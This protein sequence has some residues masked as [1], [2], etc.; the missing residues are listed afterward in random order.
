MKTKSII[1]LFILSLLLS[2]GCDKDFLTVT[3][4]SRLTSDQFWKNEDDAFKA[5]TA[6]YAQLQVPLWSCWGQYECKVLVET[7]RTDE[8]RFKPDYD[9]WVEMYTFNMTPENYTSDY[10]WYYNWKGIYQTNLVLENVPDIE[11]NEATKARFLAEAKFLRAFYH[12]KLV[13]YY[14]NIPLMIEV[15]KQASDYYPSQVAPEQIYAQVENDF[16]VAQNHLPTD[17]P[18]EELGRAT[19]G[20][21]TAFLGLAYLHQNKWAE[22]ASEFE[23]VMNMGYNL[24]PNYYDNFNGL[25]ENNEESIFEVQYTLKQP[26]DVWETMTHTAQFSSWQQGWASDWFFNLMMTDTTETGEY[27][28]RVYG[29]FVFDDPDSDVFYFEGKSYREHFGNDETKAYWKKWCHKEDIWDQP[30]LDAGG[31]NIVEMRYADVLL[32]YAE[33]QNELGNTGDAYTAINQVR[34][35]AGVAHLTSG[36][37]QAQMREHIR[38]YERPVELAIEG[39]RWADLV[40]WGNVK[41]TLQ[42]HNHP[43]VNTFDPG[44]DEYLPIPQI[45]ILNDP[46][47]IQNGG[48]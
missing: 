24:V 39:K 20:A 25:N 35:R 15:P 21:A 7:Y 8:A 45:D 22:A 3:D 10:F 48:Y 38:H 14:R 17:L 26:N 47:L 19:K 13:T 32:M 34:E 37:S 6:A 43:Y 36:M 23:K 46:N 18:D 12:L 42:G 2:F 27:S 40:R 44:I 16:R 4:P 11:M 31:I 1:I 30:Y 28:Q 9:E 33:V 41:E 29:S 5:I